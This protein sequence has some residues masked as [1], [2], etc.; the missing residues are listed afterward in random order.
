LLSKL[1]VTGFPDETTDSADLELYVFEL[2]NLA[3]RIL[4][5]LK[6]SYGSYESN[7]K[8]LERMQ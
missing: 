7:I 1:P 2:S 6:D 8:V 5:T 4:Q 3:G